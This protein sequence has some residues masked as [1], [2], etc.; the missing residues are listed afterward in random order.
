MPEFDI[1][2]VKQALGRM[3]HAINGIQSS[4]QEVAKITRVIEGIA[5]QTNILALNAAVE[6]ARTGQ[7][8]L[9]FAVAADEVRGLAQRCSAAAH[10]TASW[11]ERSLESNTSGCRSNAWPPRSRPQPR[12]STCGP[13]PAIWNKW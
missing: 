10:E 12:A 4:S 6:A 3:V 2:N 1:E 5:F 7:A 13:N 9:G 11:I 8:S